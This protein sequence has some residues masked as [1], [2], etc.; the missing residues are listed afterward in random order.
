MVQTRCS[1]RKIVT[2][3]AVYKINSTEVHLIK[4]S[5]HS[6]VIAFHNNYEVRDADSVS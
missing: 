4:I 2:R 3:N 1:N 6:T 5:F